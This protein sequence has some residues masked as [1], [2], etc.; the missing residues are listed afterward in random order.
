MGLG[1]FL[2]NVPSD[3]S[4]LA[5]GIRACSAG[6]MPEVPKAQGLGRLAHS[7]ILFCFL[8]AKRA[9][10]YSRQGLLLIQSGSDSEN[11]KRKRDKQKCGV[12]MLGSR[13]DPRSEESG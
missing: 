4:L 6:E 13:N 1:F 5:S 7:A 10:P 3:L 9:I 11:E 2:P 8:L 12:Y